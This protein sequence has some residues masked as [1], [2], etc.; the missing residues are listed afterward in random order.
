MTTE[1]YI[2]FL[3]RWAARLDASPEHVENIV[4]GIWPGLPA[5]PLGGPVPPLIRRHE[6][7]IHEV[8]L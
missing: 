8:S 4:R 3:N 6:Y 5:P 2:D 7:R 1:T